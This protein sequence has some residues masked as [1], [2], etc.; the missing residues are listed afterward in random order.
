MLRF[1]FLLLTLLSLPLYGSDTQI[2]SSNLEKALPGDYFVFSQG[3]NIT[4]LT[5]RNKNKNILVLE[6]ITAP[7]TTSLLKNKQWNK[8]IDDGA[9][10][11]TSWQVYALNLQTKKNDLIYSLSKRSW[12]KIT[13][14]EN[15]LAT[16]LTLELKPTPKNKRKKI[17]TIPL[18]GSIDRR[19]DWNPPLVYNGTKVNNAEFTPWECFWPKDHSKLSGKHLL[20]YLPTDQETYPSYFPYWLQIAGMSG[21]AKVRV[22]DTGRNLISLTPIPS[23]FTLDQEEDKR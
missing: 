8:W 5:I 18:P 19:S 1:F 4:L 21:K 20:I 7:A 16:L 2:L 12:M 22:L 15:F 6:E 3:K 17:G 14:G 10:K 9:P 23:A 11:H 13:D